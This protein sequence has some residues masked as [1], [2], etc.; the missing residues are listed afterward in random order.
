MIRGWGA[1][2][3]RLA[4]RLLMVQLVR[5]TIGTAIAI[6]AAR[7]GHPTHPAALLTLAAVYLVGTT[8]VEAVRRRVGARSARLIAGMLFIDAVTLAVA[9]DW[10]GRERSPLLFLV[11]LHITAATV[12]LSY[13]TGLKVALWHGGLLFSSAVLSLSRPQPA[14]RAA[15]PSSV[16]AEALGFLVVAAGVAA[17]AALNEHALRRGGSELRSLADLGILLGRARTQHDV[18]RALGET[19]CDKLGFVQAAIL[20]QEPDHWWGMLYGQ[21]PP[22]EVAGRG[23]ADLLLRR[24]WDGR[25]PIL[26]RRL[27]ADDAPLLDRLLFDA[28][29]LAVMP[30]AGAI[31]MV[32]IGEWSARRRGFLRAN[33]LATAVEATARA[34]LELE[35]VRLAAEVERLASRDQLTGL[36]NRRVFDEQ[37]DLLVERARRDQRPLSL[38]LLDV[39]HFKQVNDT[40]GHQVGDAVL[41]QTGAAIMAAAR[42]VDVTV[43]YG[44]EEFA[45][46]L[47][48][49]PGP[50]AVAIAQRLRAALA[51]GVSAAVI[52]ASA[53]VAT[54]PTN[55]VDADSLV[56]RA[57]EAL[58]EAKRSGRDQTVRTRIRV[59]RVA[60]SVPA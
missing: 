20:V 44:G 55:A 27:D 51:A 4:D 50:E 48:G 23:Q 12:L 43:R 54:F 58:Y 30:Y 19:I 16:A 46:L 29:N 5:A 24:A 18:A 47:P 25:E 42:A 26:L 11:Y 3:S 17:F 45:V 15:S 31:P 34:G 14:G 39:D 35:N 13:R 53:G 40:R 59:R 8:V 32:A 6:A 22:V 52:T 10:T 38:V 2:W 28:S 41:R 21:R 49:C 56:S 7:I 33:T 57:D 9:I 36:F 1:W 37:L 60:A